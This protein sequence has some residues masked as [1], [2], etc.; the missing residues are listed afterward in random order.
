MFLY[1]GHQ[2]KR[3]RH[4]ANTDSELR[5]G[6]AAVHCVRGYALMPPRQLHFRNCFRVS[7]RGRRLDGAVLACRGV[8]Q[9]DKELFSDVMPPLAAVFGGPLKQW[10]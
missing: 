6:K 5:S 3:R 1:R 4:A 10:Q 9:R 2:R 7:K 8:Q